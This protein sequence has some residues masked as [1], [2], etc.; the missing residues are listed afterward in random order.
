LFHRTIVNISRPQG[1]SSWTCRRKAPTRS[2]NW[3]LV[4]CVRRIR[5]EMKPPPPIAIVT[6]GLN[7]S[8]FGTSDVTAEWTSAKDQ[9]RVWNE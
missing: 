5:A 2:Y 8:S 9:K 6:S 1:K 3:Y 7:S 4:S